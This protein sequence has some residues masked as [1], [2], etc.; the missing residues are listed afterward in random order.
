MAAI[1]WAL[2]ATE[3]HVDGLDDYTINMGKLSQYIS[4]A[5]VVQPGLGS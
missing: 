5:S 4:E 3:Q 1:R 2:F